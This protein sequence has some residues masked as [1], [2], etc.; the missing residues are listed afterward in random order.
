MKYHIEPVDHLHGEIKIPGDKSISHRSVMLGSI[1][2]GESC[3]DDILESEDVKATIN[4]FKS[5]GVKINGPKNGRI[6]IKGN[7][8]QG[9]TPPNLSIDCGN[10]GTSI[11]LL[12]GILS[13]QNFSSI[14]IGDR[15][16]MKRPMQ[17]IA[18]PLTKMNAKISLGINGCPPIKIEPTNSNRNLIGINYELPI[19][20]AQVK[21]AIILAALYAKNRT[22][23]TEPSNSRDHTERMLSSLGADIKCKSNKI[24]INPL[25]KNKLKTLEI[26]I[27]G[28]F[29][30]AAF[31]IVAATI[32]RKGEV[33]LKNVGINPTR[34]AALGILEK[35][36]AKLNLI[37]KKIISGE[38][39]ADI[40]IKS[41]KLQGITIPAKLVSIAIDEFPILFIAASAA[42]GITKLTNA[43]ELRNKESDRLASMSAGLKT[44]GI[45]HKLMPDGIII[46]GNGDN[47]W[48][49][50]E[51]DSFSD[52]RIAMSFAVAA[53]RARKSIC[54]NN[55]QNVKTSYPNFV[56]DARELGLN[57]SCE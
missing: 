4:A 5:L 41:A 52:H 26:S 31:W 22:I 47:D 56:A 17:R 44:L 23:I 49:G 28:D 39:V 1:A 53:I 38:P 20:S 6:I 45:K 30:S 40:K 11:R 54:I 25:N 29:S 48:N 16:L 37:N 35:M 19:A 55:C 51:I 43:Q 2:I 10:S 50:G 42:K 12:T 13:A 24:I 27:P 18:D 9:F 34:I 15:S 3:I 32:A 21:S 7:G 8:I 46:E 57:V 33:L 36:G 14:L